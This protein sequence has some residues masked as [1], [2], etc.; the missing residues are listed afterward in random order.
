[1]A[2]LFHGNSVHGTTAQLA[3]ILVAV[4]LNLPVGVDH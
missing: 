3:V 2:P 1:M 4:C